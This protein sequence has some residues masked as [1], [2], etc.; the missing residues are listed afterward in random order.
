MSR[1]AAMVGHGGSGSTLNALAAGVPQAFVPLFVDG[2]ANA[3]RVAAAGAGIVAEDITADVRKLIDD[4]RY[5]DGATT[6][7]DA[8]HALPPVDD[9]VAVIQREAHRVRRSAVGAMPL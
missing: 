9:A 4:P 6:I 7:A 5:G 3:G 2:P 8:I 1:A